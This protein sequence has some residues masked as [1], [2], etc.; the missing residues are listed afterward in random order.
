[1][2]ISKPNVCHRPIDEHDRSGIGLRKETM[3]REYDSL[4]DE[5]LADIALKE[6]ESSELD[7]PSQS[8]SLPMASNDHKSTR[9]RSERIITPDECRAHI[10]LL[11]TN[12][13]SVCSLLFGRH[14]PLAHFFDGGIPAALADMF[15]MEA[16]A[17][18]P[19]RFRPPA[20]VGDVFFEHPHNVLLAKILATAYQIRDVS[21]ELRLI[22]AKDSIG[23]AEIRRRMYS[24]LLEGL[25]QL[26]VDVNSFV[27]SNKNP[28]SKLRGRPPPPGVKQGLEKKEGL[29]RMNMMVSLVI[30]LSLG[31]T[32]RELG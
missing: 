11:F 7:E 31:S 10:R 4:G 19:T 27:D 17:V 1:M 15:F 14:G 28:S 29:F 9:G 23:S 20:K 2:N 8:E 22:T 21:R 6:T 24:S 26:Q 30:C 3:P 13:T 16:I 25:I 12:E 18:T 32:K 5:N